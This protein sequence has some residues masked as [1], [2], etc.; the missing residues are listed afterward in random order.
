MKKRTTIYLKNI[1]RH[2]IYNLYQFYNKKLQNKITVYDLETIDVIKTLPADAVCVDVGVN[3]GQIFHYLYN[4]CTKGKIYGFEPIPE[5]YNYLTSTYKSDRTQFFNTALSDTEGSV[6]FFYFPKRTGISGL[7][8]REMD[9]N[10]EYKNITVQ[11]KMFDAIYPDNRLDFLKIDVEG[12][13]LNVLKGAKNS[14]YKFKP[15]IIFESGIG[16]LEHFNHTPEDLF[17][18]FDS[19]NYNLTNMKYYLSGKQPMGREEF[20]QNFQKGYDY[21]YLALPKT[22]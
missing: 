8:S 12:A 6:N 15:L 16:G 4:H 21:Q 7:S 1:V 5:L 13:E 20:I 18:F 19:V 14:I 11:L 2:F 9:K 17:N 22:K 10:H 3:E